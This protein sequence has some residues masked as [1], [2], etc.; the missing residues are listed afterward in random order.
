MPLNPKTGKTDRR[1][2]SEAKLLEFHL[3]QVKESGMQVKKEKRCTCDSPEAGGSEGSG[4]APLPLAMLAG[5]GALMLDSGG[6]SAANTPADSPAILPQP[7]LP[8][9]P[10]PA[11]SSVPKTHNPSKPLAGKSISKP[12][13]AALTQHLTGVTLE[14]PGTS[15]QLNP[16]HWQVTGSCSDALPAG[17]DRSNTARIAM[18]ENRQ[19][20]LEKRMCDFD[21]R[22][23]KLGT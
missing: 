19:D 8:E 5:L 9:D 1:A 17:D 18:L 22:L 7:P 10:A 14:V 20:E 11:P 21:H 6:S 2:L 23:K 4:P 13:L 15:K 12:L 16:V 3:K